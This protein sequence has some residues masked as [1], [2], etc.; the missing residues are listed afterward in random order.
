[1]LF[2]RRY[3]S[4]GIFLAVAAIAG[5]AGG[6]TP[7]PATSV[8][9]SPGSSIATLVAIPSTPGNVALAAVAGYSPGFAVGSGAPTGL[10]ASTTTSV[11]APP[12]APTLSVAR[13]A[14]SATSPIAPFLFVTA[15]F[16]ANVPA[17][18]IASELLQIGTSLAIPANVNY[19]CAVTDLTAGS[20]TTTFGPALPVNAIVTISNGTATS[21]P[22]F[23]ADHTYL[24]EFYTLPIPTATPTPSP[25]PTA[26]GSASP[27]PTPTATSTSS[28][29]PSPA[30]TVTSAGTATA[31]PVFTF[32]GP[33][34]TSATVTPPNA[35]PALVVGSGYGSHD[36]Q[37]SIQLGA[38]S[39]SGTYSMTAALGSVGDISSSNFPFYTGSAATPLFYV[40]LT[41]SAPVAFAQTPVIT[42]T[43]NS[44]GS[45]NTCSLFIYANTGGSAYQ[46]VQV[47]TPVNVSGTG[48]MIPAAS[49]SGITLQYSPTAAQVGFIGC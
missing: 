5:C 3:L 28:P 40:Q 46:W 15:S 18:V 6:S 17:G 33:S 32:T 24:F 31:P 7:G 20:Q 16:S 23:I 8:T 30:P 29:T 36:A 48:V 35:P 13:K 34:A 42:V 14:Q 38:A 26:S 10:T 22:A 21:A 47:G 41:P 25:T 1:V 49:A 2:Q 43:V 9:A 44:F 39:S 27:T 19:F 37:V 11:T 4:V 12:G 45:T